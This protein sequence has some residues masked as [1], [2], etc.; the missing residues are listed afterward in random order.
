M[1]VVY[2]SVFSDMAAQM[3]RLLVDKEKIEWQQRLTFI[4]HLLWDK[5]NYLYALYLIL[6]TISWGHII[7]PI[8]FGE[9]SA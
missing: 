5:H 9:N 4:N 2:G 8:Y 1:A 7:I 6:S 3:P